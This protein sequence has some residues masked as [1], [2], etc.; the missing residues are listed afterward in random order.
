MINGIIVVN[1]PA[2]M[3]SADVVYKLRKILQ[4]KKI[5]HAG[6]L[7]PEVSGVLPIAVGQA[8]KLIDLLHENFKE[9]QGIGRLGVQTDTGDLTGKIV[10]TKSLSKPFDRAQIQN[11]MKQ[12]TGEIM[13]VPPMYSAVKINGK[14]LYEY[15]RAGEIV[16]VPARP[17][18]VADFEITAD[19]TFDQNKKTEDFQFLATVSKGTYI[20]T[21][22]EQVAAELDYPGVMIHLVRTKSAGYAL[23]DAVTLDFIEKNLAEP[24]SFVQP[25][26]TV[27]SEMK[28]VNLTA[29]EFAKVQN[30]VKLNL[31]ESAAKIALVFQDKI[32]AIYQKEKEHLYRSDLMLLKNE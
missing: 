18:T 4:I 15:A 13:Q 23:N 17:I 1:K 9:Y 11:A 19:P 16:D 8:T 7:D 26:E 30:G 29:A 14:K 28:K 32:K 24:K 6:T 5:G 31:D 20:R 27:F 12:L 25:I 10:A 21:L 2:G 22:V 3:T